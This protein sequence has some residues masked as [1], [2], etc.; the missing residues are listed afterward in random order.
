MAEDEFGFNVIIRP[1]PYICAEWEGGGYPQWLAT[2]RPANYSGMWLRSDDPEYLKWCKHWFTAVAKVVGPHQI[3]HRPLGK[4]GVILWQIENEYNYDAHSE[5][6]KLGQLQFLGKVSKDL[7]IDVPLFTCVSHN[8]TLQ[9][10]D[11]M[12]QNV[13]ETVNQ[14]PGMDLDR[15][16]RDISYLKS[17]EPTK[18]KMITELQGGWFSSIGNPR[19]SDQMGHTAMQIQRVTL[20]AWEKGF[21]STNYYMAFGGTNPGDW[22]AQG[23]LRQRTTTMP[24]FAKQAE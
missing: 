23:N 21:T 24:P 2:K 15:M 1:G 16:A 18:P 8:H 9:S 3:T 14:Y 17:Y 10:D 6:A 12:K 4:P 11:W 7:G 19:M 20:L 13:L 22:G 5:K